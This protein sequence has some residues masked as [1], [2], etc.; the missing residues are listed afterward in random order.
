MKSV[1]SIRW[2][3]AVKDSQIAREWATKH[4]LALRYGVSV[5]C[6]DNWVYQKRIPSV[7][8]GRLIRFRVARCDEA[9]AK[10]ERREAR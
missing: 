4:E 10:F 6:I 8:L 7:K 9:L 3:S 1:G 5:R 2:L